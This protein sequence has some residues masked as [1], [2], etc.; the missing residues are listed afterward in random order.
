MKITRFSVTEDHIK[1]LK[2]M[3]IGWQD[4]EFGAPEVDPKRPYGNSDV[5]HD[6]AEILD[7]PYNRNPETYEYTDL[8]I[9]KMDKIHREM[10][11]V[12]QI[13][14]SNCSIRPGTYEAKEFS[15]DWHRVN[16]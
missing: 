15:N 12:L 16:K 2:S 6:I 13:L 7:W 4:C 5:Y 10:E 9:K 11:T 1:L 14:V 8:A 3:Y